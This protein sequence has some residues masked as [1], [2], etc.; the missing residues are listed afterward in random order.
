V[1]HLSLLG[2][3]GKEYSPSYPDH[4]AN[5]VGRFAGIFVENLSIFQFHGIGTWTPAG[6]TACNYSTSQSCVADEVGD[7]GTGYYQTVRLR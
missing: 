7:L 5:I 1:C 2:E 4:L 6:F 3:I